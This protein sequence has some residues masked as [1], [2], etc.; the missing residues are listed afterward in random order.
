MS[1]TIR[2]MKPDEYPLLEDFLYE[3]IYIPQGMA[4]P[5]RSILDTPELQVYISGFGTQIHD[6]AMVA[7][8]DGKVVGAIWVRIMND[9]GH[10]DNDTPSLAI[11]LFQEYRGLGIG[12]AL[13][14]KM[15]DQLKEDGYRQVSLSVQKD[16]YAVRL[17]QKTGFEIVSE[18]EEEYIMIKQ[19]I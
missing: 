16:N 4:P 15:L 12:T 7:E 10:I 8:V 9:Y 1:I 2:E 11:S 19:T 17:Y 5:P 13:M 6:K 3:A 14:Q 18:N